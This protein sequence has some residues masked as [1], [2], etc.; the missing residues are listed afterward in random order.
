[1]PTS[2]ASSARL[3]PTSTP[4]AGPAHQR[5]RR[6]P[7]SATCPAP[8]RTAS[9]AGARATRSSPAAEAGHHRAVDGGQPEPGRERLVQRGDV[10][11]PDQ[12]LRARGGQRRPSRA[13]RPSAG[14]RTRRGRRTPPA[15]SGSHQA[16]HQVRRR[17]RRRRRRGSR[18]ARGCRA[19]ARRPA[20]RAPRTPARRGRRRAGRAAPARPGRHHGDPVAGRAAGA[21]RISERPGFFGA[22]ASALRRRRPARD[23][24]A[25]SAR[26]SRPGVA[27]AATTASYRSAGMS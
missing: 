23:Q 21:A 22:S 11:E 14:R 6:A 18:T 24:P 12:H 10:G 20:R 2:A 9:R 5:R 16:A 25:R 13:G 15:P 8:A 3:P 26:G 19:R 1:M 7:G 17:G 4:S 27:P